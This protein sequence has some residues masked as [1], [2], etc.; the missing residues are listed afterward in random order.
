VDP[1]LEQVD[2]TVAARRLFRHRQK[3]LV[4]VSGGVDSM[5]LLRLLH[6][7]SRKYRWQLTV[8]H[9][10]HGLRGRSSDADERLVVRTAKQLGC[11]AVT[12]RVDVKQFARE[13]K[14]SLEMAARG[15]RHEFLARTAA[16]L[17]IGAIALAHHADDQ[18][19]LFFL[20]L[21]RG[22][23]GEGQAG[24]KWRGVSPADSKIEL[25][26][27]LLTAK[28]TA[29]LEF[30]VRNKVH[31][32]E[33]ASNASLDIRR[34]RIR[35]ELLPLLR[36]SYQPALDEIILRL[37]GIVG[38]EAEFVSQCAEAWLKEGTGFEQLPV[39]VQRR[40]LHL[41][42]T[43]AGIAG[44]FE[45]IEKLRVVADEPISVARDLAVARDA[46]GR[47]RLHRA[48]IQSGSPVS[49]SIKLV[50]NAGTIRFSGMEIS[51]RIVRQR[52]SGIPMRQEQCEVFDANEV[53]REIILRHWLPGDRFQ[54]IGMSKPVKLQDLFTNQKIPR[55]RRRQLVVATTASGELFWVEGLRLSE[56]FKLLQRTVSRLKWCWK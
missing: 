42:L 5:V 45:L 37:G 20:R 43:R 17:K 25:I 35:H 41:Q 14:L 8:A 51:W 31:F 52:S 24:M 29:L 34:N 28:K 46:A 15:L 47:L 49:L 33:D 9:L 50:G 44:G 27:P 55:E 2:Q 12:E 18:V 26:R 21:F 19:E 22:S 6:E 16:R 30:A 10:N 40:C 3:L 54:P 36:R 4:A 32:R 56:R 39:A 53:G 7:L 13:R 23:G 11:A 1:L 38:A 48:E